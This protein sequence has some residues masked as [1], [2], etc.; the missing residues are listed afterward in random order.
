MMHIPV[1]VSLTVKLS[2]SKFRICASCPFFRRV[3]ESSGGVGAAWTSASA[4]VETTTKAR[5]IVYELGGI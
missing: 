1:Q 4:R 3:A 2:N 5:N